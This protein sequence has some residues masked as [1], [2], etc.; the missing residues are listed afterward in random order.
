MQDLDPYEV[1]EAVFIVFRDVIML[2]LLGFVTSVVLLLPHVNPPQTEAKEAGQTPGDMIIE[3][4]WPDELDTDVDLWVEAPGDRPVGYS[5]RGGLIFNLLR[6]DLGHSSDLTNLNYEFAYSR[7]APAGEYTVNLHLYRNMS[8]LEH[9]PV[10]VVVS[11]RNEQTRSNHVV[12]SENVL[13]T[14]VNQEKTVIR[15]SLADNGY[16]VPGS[17]NYIFKPLRSGLKM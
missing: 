17:S 10:N 9:I 4:R 6:D 11:L 15:F 13:L 12:A 5:N 7:G 1:N 3:I 14:R 2:A 16:L 8:K